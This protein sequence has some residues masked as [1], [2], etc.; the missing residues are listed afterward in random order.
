MEL[1]FPISKKLVNNSSSLPSKN[2]AASASGFPSPA[3]AG[4]QVTPNPLEQR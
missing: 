3:R 1:I 2:A 4:A